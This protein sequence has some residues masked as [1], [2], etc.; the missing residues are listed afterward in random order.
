MLEHIEIGVRQGLRLLQLRE[1]EMSPD[2]RVSL[3]RRV[4]AIAAPAG[5][6]V[7]LVG[8]ALEARRAGLDGVHSTAE[9]VQ[10]LRGRPPVKLWLCSCHD[11]ADLERATE[12]GADAVVVSPVLDNAAH[13][14]RAAL[15]WD[16]LQRLSQMASVPLYAQG[17]IDAGLVASAQRA[18]A[19]GIATARWI[20]TARLSDPARWGDSS[21]AQ[22][23]AP[24][25]KRVPR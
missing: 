8:S 5:A 10:R 15:G 4:N 6:R 18:G 20:H 2:Q 12:L 3:A 7:L 24:H 1:P 9:E 11:E 17:G 19:V 21:A 14:E 25:M 22:A 13:P 16:G 23:D